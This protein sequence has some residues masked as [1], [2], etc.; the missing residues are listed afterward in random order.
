V[1]YAQ[2]LVTYV[3][4]VIGAL[5]PIANPFSTAPMFLSLTANFDKHER[6]KTATLACLYMF[7]LLT[8]FLLAGVFLLGFFGVSLIS[9]KI[10]GGLIILY[11]GFRMLF[12][13]PTHTQQSEMTKQSAADVAFVPLAMPMLSG[14]GSISV[15]IAIAAEVG[16]IESAQGQFIGYSVVAA[17]IA[18]ASL[19]CWFVLSASNKVIRFL[20]QRGI[21]AMTKV[22]GFFLIAIGVEFLGGGV[23]ALLAV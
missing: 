20:G 9:L 2:E 23:S 17:G 1:E 12:P 21:D 5:I 3:L 15:V 8:M 6:R 11:I 7:G 14:P 13:P 19:I 16:Q 22:M 18:A 4:L 10:A